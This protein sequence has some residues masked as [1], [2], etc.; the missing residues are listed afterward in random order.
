M[1]HSATDH[2]LNRVTPTRKFVKNSFGKVL[3]S[4]LIKL[5][6][7]LASPIADLPLGTRF[8][9]WITVYPDY[10]YISCGHSFH[11]IAGILLFDHLE[12]KP[13]TNY[14]GLLVLWWFLFY[15]WVLKVAEEI[16]Q[17]VEIGSRI[18]TNL[19]VVDKLRAYFYDFWNYLDVAL[20]IAFLAFL[21][22]A[23]MK[24][25]FG[26]LV[27]FK[28]LPLVTELHRSFAVLAMVMCSVNFAKISKYGAKGVPV[29]DATVVMMI[30]FFEYMAAIS[31]VLGGML[32]ST[33]LVSEHDDK[34]ENFKNMT[35]TSL[36][37][38]AGMQSKEEV[39]NA[40]WA[41]KGQN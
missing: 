31:P 30:A 24:T 5:V 10:F 15:L 23:L 13:G 40:Q 25:G 33:F 4:F 37:S 38:I 28:D 20:I 1:E 8:K 32:L 3:R 19:S 26:K 35:F 22:T 36:K 39:L 18:R 29:I 27:E 7:F 41:R 6:M 21:V 12:S 11:M 16:K 2:F 34:M 14:G 9:T 17:Y